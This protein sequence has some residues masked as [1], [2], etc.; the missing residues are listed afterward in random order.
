M[1]ATSLTRAGR[2]DASYV[3]F[4]IDSGTEVRGHLPQPKPL[5]AVADRDVY[6]SHCFSD[7]S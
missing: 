7:F 6:V 3:A 1:R 2:D 5:K 4:R